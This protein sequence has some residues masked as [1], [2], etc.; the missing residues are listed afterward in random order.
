MG[1]AEFACLCV[2]L[3]RN[4][5]PLRRARRTPPQICKP[6]IQ[7]AS[8]A[9]AAILSRKLDEKLAIEKRVDTVEHKVA[10][11]EYQLKQA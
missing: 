7:G 2:L 8:Q 4:P 11:I 3:L 10:A 1:Y 9:K 6:E 5:Y